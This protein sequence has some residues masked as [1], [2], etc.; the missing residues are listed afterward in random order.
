MFLSR[1]YGPHVWFG[2]TNSCCDLVRTL[3]KFHLSIPLPREIDAWSKLVQKARGL[4]DSDPNTPII[5]RYTERVVS[6][7][8]R[9]V[10]PSALDATKPWGSQWE[11]AVQYPNR[12]DDWMLHYAVETC[13]LDM[14]RFDTWMNQATIM[15]SLM[16]PPLLR[17]PPPP[18][19][20]KVTVTIDEDTKHVIPPAGNNAPPPPTAPS[21]PQNRRARRTERART[22]AQRPPKP[23]RP[24]PTGPG[25]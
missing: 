14:P 10:L 16:Q 6:L 9:L 8:Q 4:N 22:F 24:Q 13:R 23:T 11:R 19:T 7:S 18:E 1:V 21:E 5:G 15:T 25:R 2:D 12:L 17:E 3:S 20:A